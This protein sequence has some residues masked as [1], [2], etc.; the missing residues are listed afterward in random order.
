MFGLSYM[1]MA[2]HVLVGVHEPNSIDINV[3]VDVQ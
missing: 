2:I 3:L 1:N